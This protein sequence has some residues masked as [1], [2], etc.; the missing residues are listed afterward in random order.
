MSDAALIWVASN[1]AVST[2]L[3]ATA[4]LAQQHARFTA[5]AHLLWITAL[6]KLVTPPLFR[7]PVLA[8][9][10]DNAGVARPAPAVLDAGVDL[11]PA[12][13]AMIAAL[14]RKVSE[15]EIA[16]SRFSTA[17]S[18]SVQPFSATR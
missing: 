4:W 7:V 15:R 2:A 12:A 9:Q 14:T 5:V 1:L 11:V 18:S 8:A 17:R 10:T 3:A 16:A 6:V 13:Q